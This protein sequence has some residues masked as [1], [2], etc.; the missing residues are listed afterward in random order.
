MIIIGP[1][2][3]QFARAFCAEFD[4]C[5]K[6]E[7][8]ISFGPDLW[9]QEEYLVLI[10]KSGMDLDLSAYTLHAGDDSLP[11]TDTLAAGE[12]IIPGFGENAAD[13]AQLVALP[14]EWEP[15]VRMQNTL[16]L[17]DR[18]GIVSV[19]HQSGAAIDVFSY[20]GFYGIDLDSIDATV[21]GYP[22]LPC[23]GV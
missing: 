13:F 15:A 11:L 3:N 10:N 1:Y 18:G 2:S 5:F 20:G 7:K 16:R 6:S 17:N 8:V 22:P 14:A 21:R 9:V 23:L 12:R 19:V 4:G